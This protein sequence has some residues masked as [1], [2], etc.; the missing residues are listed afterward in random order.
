MPAK[1]GRSFQRRNRVRHRAMRSEPVVASTKLWSRASPGLT[2]RNGCSWRKCRSTCCQ[3]ATR[4]AAMLRAARRF[5]VPRQA[6]VRNWPRPAECEVLAPR[7]G[8]PIIGETP[9]PRLTWLGRRMAFPP[10][11][12]MAERPRSGAPM[13]KGCTE[14]GPRKTVRTLTKGPARPGLCLCRRVMLQCRMDRALTV[15]TPGGPFRTGFPD[16]GRQMTM[17]A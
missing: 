2:E 7:F 11:I 17:I 10:L 9:L 14:R 1:R 12:S 13:E 6:F 16:H 4:C 8:R 15:P 5:A 3:P